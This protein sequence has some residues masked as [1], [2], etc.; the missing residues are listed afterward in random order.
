MATENGNKRRV[1]LVEQGAYT[2][3]VGQT[4]GNSSINDE[5]LDA[6]DKIDE[7]ARYI[8]GK[9]SWSSSLTLNLDNTANAKQT[10]FIKKLAAGQPVEIFVGT[11]NGD[12]QSDG[13]AGTAYVASIED[14]FDNGALSTRSVNLTGNGEPTIIYPEA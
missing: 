10:E 13:I 11:L 8:S 4:S 1:Y 14:T 12:Q 7:W 2:Y 9:K 5:L 3:V 6:S